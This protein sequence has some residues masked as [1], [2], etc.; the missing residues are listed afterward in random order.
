MSAGE[1]HRFVRRRLPRVH[2][3]PA[4]L[5]LLPLE[6]IVRYMNALNALER[7]L[8]ITRSSKLASHVL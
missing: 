7:T 8:V 1:P 4:A 6:A 3:F 5:F 2:E